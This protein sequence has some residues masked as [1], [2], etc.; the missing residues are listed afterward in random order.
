[1]PQ[2]DRGRGENERRGEVNKAI[3]KSMNHGDGPFLA[4][5]VPVYNEAANI[6]GCLHGLMHQTLLAHQH[7]ILVLDGG[8]TDG[9]PDLLMTLKQRWSGPEYPELRVIENPERT[10]PHARNLALKHLPPSVKFLVEMIGHA[11]VE[12]DHLEQRL[13]AWE[14]CTNLASRPL[15]GVGVRVV[16]SN[17]EQG[18]ASR[19][20]EAVL[21]SKFGQSGGQFSPFRETGPTDVPAF[22]MHDRD[23][24]DAV[25]GWDTTF[26]TSQDSDLSMR[27][28]KAGYSL[29]RTP[30]PTVAMHKRSTLG[31]WWRMGHRYGFWRTKVLLRHPRRAKWQEFLPW[32]G[33]IS[34]FGL[35]LGGVG[36]WWLPSALYGVVLGCLGILHGSAQRSAMSVV[37]VPLCMV[38]LHTSFSLG[39]VDGLVRRG[40]LPRD[41]D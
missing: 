17:R 28:L 39:L 7:M 10:V 3:R 27:L 33:L 40:R 29:Y 35:Y 13:A 41:R 23:A 25:G 19:W 8:S 36:L 1:V 16:A 37:G 20:I 26:V 9:T 22:V 30:E 18:H 4:T 11:A 14:R 5:I 6:E 34:T 2:E 12:N 15:A 21:G 32:I 38:M 24:V 31:Q